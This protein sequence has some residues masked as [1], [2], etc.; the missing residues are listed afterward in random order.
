MQSDTFFSAAIVT[1]MIA[2][3][4]AAATTLGAPAASVA[5]QRQMAAARPAAVTLPTVLV[6]GRR[7][8]RVATEQ[9]TP[10]STQVQ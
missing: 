7:D 2:V 9:T 3:G 8:T 6:T 4:A 10:P 1:A 5:L